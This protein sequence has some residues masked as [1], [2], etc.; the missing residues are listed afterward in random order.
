MEELDELSFDN[1]FSG[2]EFDGYFGQ[3]QEENNEETPE[4]KNDKENPEEEKENKDT[5]EEKGEK[6]SN[7]ESVDGDENKASEEDTSPKGVENSSPDFYSSIAKALAGDGVLKDVKD[8]DIK[9]IT[10]AEDFADLIDKQVQNQLTE[11]QRRIDEALRYGV[12]TDDIKKY[13]NII[14]NLDNITEEALS[15]EDEKSE[16]LRKNLIY[17]DYINRGFSKERAT[18]E[19]NRSF[20]AG[21]DIDDA[22]E[23][24]QSNKEYFTAQYNSLIKEAK[25]EAEETKKKYKK[26]AEEL[27]DSIV[28]G[29]KAFGEV[30]VD[31]KTRQKVYDSIMKPVYTDPDTGERLTAIQKYE[32]ENKIDFIKNVGLLY[33]LT[34]GFK[35]VG[36]LLK[37][38]VKKE[39]NKNLK[40][41]ESVI[42]NTSRTSSGSLDF[43][44]GL[45][46]ESKSIDWTPAF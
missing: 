43:A 3:S 36:G 21:T 2:D 39:V 32:R 4:E 12:E 26:Q 33:V 6:S 27:K 25:K 14:E 22:K 44:S 11:R 18:R 10:S 42:N 23:A 28:N 5:I 24:I 41:L 40:E 19:V 7:P 17:Q 38:Q 20:D 34:D 46:D 29:E 35:K 9:E 45:G 31:R 37:G 13:E 16:N 30:E 1:I 8:E 15:G